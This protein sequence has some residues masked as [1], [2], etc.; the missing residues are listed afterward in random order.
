[1]KKAVL[2][3]PVHSIA[4]NRP[5]TTARPFEPRLSAPFGLSIGS[6]RYSRDRPH[7]AH[8]R[9]GWNRDRTE[10]FAQIELTGHYRLEVHRRPPSLARQIPRAAANNRVS[11]VKRMNRHGDVNTPIQCLISGNICT[12]KDVRIFEIE[13]NHENRQSLNYWIPN[14]LRKSGRHHRHPDRPSNTRV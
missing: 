5:R 1:M 9:I 14:S 2:R 8:V 10:P 4:L 11:A 7:R 13:I 12:A 6:P 3:T